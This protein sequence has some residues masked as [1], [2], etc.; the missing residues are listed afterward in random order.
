M[1]SSMNSQTY[2]ESEAFVHYCARTFR[3][4]LQSSARPG[5]I[6]ELE[7]F[8]LPSQLRS[9][10]GSHTSSTHAEETINP[11]A[12]G[13]LITLLDKEVTFAF[14]LQERWLAADHPLTRWVMLRTG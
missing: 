6:H 7:Y 1:R 9:S 12:L 4:L 8:H 10:S 3:N 5:T 14:A 11:Y 13:A 2:G